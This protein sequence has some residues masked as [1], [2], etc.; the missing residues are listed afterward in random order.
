MAAVPDGYTDLLER[1]LYRHLVTARPDAGPLQAVV[2]RPDQ[3]RD[4]G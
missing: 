1:P 4:R 2:L 3:T